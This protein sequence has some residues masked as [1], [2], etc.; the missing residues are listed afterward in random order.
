MGLSTSRHVPAIAPVA[1]AA[2]FVT[3]YIISRQLRTAEVEISR[4]RAEL[5]RVQ[6]EKDAEIDGV[7]QDKYAELECV[8][9]EMERLKTSRDAAFDALGAKGSANMSCG[10][11]LIPFASWGRQY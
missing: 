11:G 2:L 6:H 10:E 8:R 1:A 4:L 5:E 3:C 9:R 7:R